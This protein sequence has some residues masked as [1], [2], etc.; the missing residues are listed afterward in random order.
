MIR[1]MS[2]IIK[3]S[4][5]SKK[6]AFFILAIIFI[7]FLLLATVTPLSG[8]DWTWASK[9]GMHRLS[10]GF[11]GYNGRLLSN[12][13][14]II[15]T[16]VFFIRIFL[17]AILGTM[18]IGWTSRLV[19][20]QHSAHAWH[21]LLTIGLFLTM[22]TEIY[23]QTFGWFAGFINYILGMLPVFYFIYWLEK[24]LLVKNKTHL[25]TLFG[26]FILGITSCLIIENITIYSVV[27]GIGAIVYFLVIN[28]SQLPSIIA[29]TL[30]TVL[31]AITMFS[32]PI[33]VSAL[34]GKD[35]F[36]HVAFGVQM[37]NTIVKIYSTS[38]YKFVFQENG[39]IIFII[40]TCL[41]VCMWQTK[42]NLIVSFLKFLLSLILF[43]YSFFAAFIRN[44]FSSANFDS[45]LILNILSIFSI[46][47]VVALCLSLVFVNSL[48]LRTKLIFYIASALLLSAPFAVITPYGPRCAFAT[49]S[50]MI[51]AAL[52]LV[53][54][55]SSLTIK[56]D[57]THKF[58]YMPLIFGTFSMIFVL[59]IM[60]A[61]GY[62]NHYRPAAISSQLRQRKTTV[63]VSRLPF[64]QY[65]WDTSPMPNRV[66]HLVYM[67]RM[68]IPEKTHN[69]VFVPFKDWK[70]YQKSF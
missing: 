48:P 50:F 59:G 39:V 56:I 54:Y 66:Q 11:V 30:G 2:Q 12:I 42:S 37:W 32:N 15:I 24:H 13:L 20:Y 5:S 14:E 60:T 51:L 45:Q 7:F 63:Y 47:F 10:T 55:I 4:K 34:S 29:Y 6:A 49:V 23:S 68:H 62:V 17:Y 16:R 70:K 61:N 18:L 28:K 69:L 31:G 53:N 57:H 22:S 26:M 8:D 52:E 36:R 1:S 21:Y 19:F 40:S 9:I 58:K 27:L 25:P 41:I 33:Y 46:V 35:N 3:K 43:S 65:N 67:R 64:Q 38:M 44:L